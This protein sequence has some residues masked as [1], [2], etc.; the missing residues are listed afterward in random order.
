MK[1]PIRDSFEE[2]IYKKNLEAGELKF[3]ENPI[4]IVSSR[5]A[6]ELTEKNLKTLSQ[7]TKRQ[8]TI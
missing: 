4:A 6:R 8:F 2:N 7:L 5:K 3:G 1:N